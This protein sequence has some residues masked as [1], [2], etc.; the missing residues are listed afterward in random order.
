MNDEQKRL[1]KGFAVALAVHLVAAI[2]IGVFGYRFV[3]RPPEVL[4]VTLSGSGGSQAADSEEIEEQVEQEDNSI[5]HSIDDI[6][7]KRLKPEIQHKKVVKKAAKAATNNNTSTSSNAG[8]GQGSGTNNEQGSG[9]GNGEGDGQGSGNDSGEGCGV[10]VTPPRI[11]SASEP[12]YPSNLRNQGIE[13]TAGIR[14]L[15]GADGRVQE[16]SVVSSSGYP[17]MD[18]SAVN[19]VYK[20]RFSPAKDKYGQKAACYVTRG[21]RFS[22]RR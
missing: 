12:R 13:G 4:E 9:S 15:V 19:A 22:L 1:G 3:T 8:N 18:E 2:V 17:E 7:D 11:I 5:M 10:P 20:W 21:I 16:V 14:M 6:I